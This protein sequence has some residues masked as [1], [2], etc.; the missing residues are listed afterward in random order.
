LRDG[1]LEDQA[2]PAAASAAASRVPLCRGRRFQPEIIGHAV[3]RHFR[4]HQSHRD[5]EDR[6]AE[7]GTQVSYEA[8]RLWCRKLGQASAARRRGGRGGARGEWHRDAVALTIDGR[9]HWQRTGATR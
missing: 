9:R 7:R 6:L 8:I 4:F 5:A 1:A 2:M 3:W